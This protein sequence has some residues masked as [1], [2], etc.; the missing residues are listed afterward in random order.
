MKLF[1][2]LTVISVICVALVSSEAG[3]CVSST[4]DGLLDI[5]QSFKY[6]NCKENCESVTDSSSCETFCQRQFS[7]HSTSVLIPRCKKYCNDTY[8]WFYSA[9][10]FTIAETVLQTQNI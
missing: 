10:R 9:N 1:A 7:D 3:S 2:F 6:V 8:Q 4:C 5:N